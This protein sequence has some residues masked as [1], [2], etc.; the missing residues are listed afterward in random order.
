MEESLPE[1]ASVPKSND[2]PLNYV[3]TTCGNKQYIVFTT[4][5]DMGT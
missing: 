5:R 2:A 1:N 4:L 3:D